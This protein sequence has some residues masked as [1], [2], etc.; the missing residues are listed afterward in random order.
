MERGK[1][2]HSI[3][4]SQLH[5]ETVGAMDF[6]LQPLLRGERLILRPV[7]PDDREPLWQVARDPLLWA[8]HPD[9]TRCEPAGFAR[10][11]EAALECGSAL[12][13]LDAATQRVIGSSRFYDWDPGAREVA[14]GYTFLAREFWGGYANRDMKQL[15]IAHAARW[16]ERIWF[17]VGKHNLRSRR[18]MEKIGAMAAFEGLRPQNGEMIEFV[19][20]RVDVAGW[21][22]P[23]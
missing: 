20:Y 23:P 22:P 21:N 11:F 3:Q 15:M 13:V 9:K 17:H 8:L 10:F 4:T 12:V 14:I 1:P 6:D 2:W 5:F 19:Y 16:A 18:A 7:R